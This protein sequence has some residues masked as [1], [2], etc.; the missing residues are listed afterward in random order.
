MPGEEHPAHRSF[1][2][3][4]FQA[5]A[6]EKIPDLFGVAL[7]AGTVRFGAKLGPGGDR[8]ATGGDGAGQLRR[9]GESVARISRKAPLDDARQGDAA[10]PQ[11]RQRGIHPLLPGIPIVINERWATLPRFA[12]QNAEGKDIGAKVATVPGAALRGAKDSAVAQ[13][14]A[15]RIQQ[16]GL[17]SRKSAKQ[18]QIG[19]AKLRVEQTQPAQRLEQL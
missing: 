5:I 19:G 9:A 2:E 8:R 18:E 11:R 17:E 14:S 3:Q 10:S 16:L 4:L 15:S 13:P 7:F 12:H 6:S 1:A